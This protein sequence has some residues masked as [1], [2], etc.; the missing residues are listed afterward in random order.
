MFWVL[1]QSLVDLVDTTTRLAGCLLIILIGLKLT[2][3][4]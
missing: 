1:N 4:K 3:E 2:D